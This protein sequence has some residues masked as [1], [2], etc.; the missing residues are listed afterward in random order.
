LPIPHYI[1][2][3]GKT[4]A[5]V[6][7][8]RD[9]ANGLTLQELTVRTGQV[10]S[11]IHRILR[12]LM[13]HGYIEQSGAGGA[14][15]LGIQFLVLAQGVRVSTNLIE[16]ARPYSRDL[17]DTFDESSYIAVLRNGRGVFIDVQETRRDLRLVGP[18]GAD[19]H[20]HATAAGK[21]MAAFFPRE[22]VPAL[23]RSIRNAPLTKRT[24]LSRS[25]IEQEWEHVRREGFAV[26]DEETIV[27]AVFLAAPFFDS[28]HTVC[29]SISVGV[30]KARYSEMLGARIAAQL[31]DSCRR[32]SNALEAVQYVHEN[33]F[34]GLGIAS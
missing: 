15:R 16:L 25:R 24:L 17:L 2:L 4:L 12:S 29:G 27:G 33:S 6:E 34:G 10:K 9:Q 18:L 13:H 8:L 1:E 11:S 7:A 23:L 31:K 21:S 3:I 28:T 19:V 5:V 22:L 20:F 26:N 30:P 14:Y 32:L